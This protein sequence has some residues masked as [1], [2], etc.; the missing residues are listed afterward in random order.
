M[1]IRQLNIRRYRSLEAF[2]WKPDPGINCL[3]G[4]GDSGKSTVLSAI[5]LLLAPYQLSGCSEFDYHRR[6]LA[7]GFEI[8]AYIGQLDLA[9]IG[10]DQRVPNLYGWANGEPTP[11]P[12]NAEAVL[13]CRVRGTPDLEL[14]YD[15][16]TEGVESPPTFPPALRRK[17]LL[18]R[19]AGEDR[20]ARDLRLGTGSLLDRHISTRDIRATI[21]GVMADAS[22]ALDVPAPAHAA[23]VE[24]QRLFLESGLPADLHLTLVPSQ[25]NSLVG[26]VALASGLEAGEAIPI[27]HAGAGTRQLALLSLSS[28]L[29]GA[30]PILVI[31]EPERGLEPYRQRTVMSRITSLIGAAGQAFITTHS[32]TILS[33]VPARGVW[34]VRVGREPL[35]FEGE[36]FQRLLQGQ[37]EAFFAPAPILCEGATEIGLLDIWLPG[38][39]GRDPESKGVML[40]DGGGQPNVLD[41][42]DSF[43]DAGIPCGLFVDDEEAHR[44][45]RENLRGR[46]GAFIW[47]D[48]RNP[49]EA[50]CRWLPE[51]QLFAVVDAAAEAAD[52]PV[53]YFEDQLWE[54][55]P[56]GDHRGP[57]RELRVVGYPE[58]LLRCALLATMT[59]CGW[60]KRRSGGRALARMIDRIGMPAE[61]RQ[62]LDAFGARLRAVMGWDAVGGGAAGAP[63]G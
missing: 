11:L 31:D 54:R 58:Q 42:G 26:M 63:I 52:A 56:Q 39:I 53:R 17:L 32:P 23:L 22:R 34:R 2:E 18:G 15:L 33:N 9:A 60:F 19:L 36:P 13:R 6:R 45:R 50:V 55:I 27:T 46:C 20:A 7:D 37:A 51:A 3:I 10:A 47:G 41:I 49:E 62:Q 35:R 14:V 25:G 43:V 59:E 1:Q 44:G 24:L 38:L 16:P 28:A 21:H 29:V 4:P 61:I 30:S 40:I 48:V 57:P 12:E 5:S 8:E